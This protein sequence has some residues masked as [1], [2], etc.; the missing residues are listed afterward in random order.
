LRL[1]VAVD[2]TSKLEFLG[3]RIR[4]RSAFQG[5]ISG[6]GWTSRSYSNDVAPDRGTLRT[7]F[8]DT[9]DAAPRRR[10]GLWSG[11]STA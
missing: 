4:S 8:R 11:W 9:L 6:S 1:F 5:P 2:R 3:A 7:T 10:E